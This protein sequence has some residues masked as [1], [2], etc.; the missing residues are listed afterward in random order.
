MASHTE[1]EIKFDAPV[2]GSLPDLSGVGA[3]VSEPREVRLE[4]T[5]FDTED[6]R[7]ARRRLTLRRRTG[8]DDAGWHLKLPVSADERIEVRRPLGRAT[9]KAPKPLVDEVRAIVRDRPLTPIAVLATRRVERHLLDEQ[10]RGL[11]V[12][13]DDTVRAERLVGEPTT[14]SWREVEVELLDGDRGVL[15]GVSRRLREGGLRRSGAASKL[16][17]ALGEAVDQQ[18]PL[19]APDGQ[20]GTTAGEVLW[21]HL[22]QQVTELLARDRAARR[23]EPDGVHKMRVATRRLRSAMATYRPVLQR[24]QTDPIRAE[25]KWLGQQLG[26]ARDAEVQL[27]RLRTLV[28]E[29]P[30]D[31]VLGPVRRRIDLE[32]RARHRAAH[33][34]LVDALDSARYW[35]LL[36]SLDDLLEHPAF[37]AQARDKARK[38]LPKVVRKAV[39][40][41][42]KA[43]DVA[44]NTSGEE[45]DHALHDVRKAAKRARY[46]AETAT[47]VI[48]KPAKRLARRMED[49]QEV[50]G[51]HQDSVTARRLLRELAVAAHGGSENGFTFGL[52]HREELARGQAAREAAYPTLRKARAAARGWPG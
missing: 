2:E 46:A 17:R 21:R 42:E 29:V 5:Y 34:A 30:D 26:R 25:L 50:L 19:A 3:A 4:A 10:G 1:V 49:V 6:L 27:E 44:A 52:L 43:A 35:H 28:E 51:E 47:P 14:T 18:G 38:R 16:V 15:E 13:S 36:E 22:D 40:R 31:L 39:R 41:V 32:L 7:L 45:H 48:G 8:G 12:V 11:A 9:A 23:D 24:S 33:A 37:T 20:K